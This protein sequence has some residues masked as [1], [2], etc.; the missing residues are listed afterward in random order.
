MKN[1]YYFLG[2]LMV[3]LVASSCKE[4]GEGVPPG[5]VTDVEAA[6][7]YGEVLLDWTN[8]SDENYYYVDISFVDSKGVNRS[9]KVSRYASGD[10]ITGFADT[11]AYTFSLTSYSFTGEASAPVTITATPLEPAFANVISTVEMVPDFGGAIVSWENETGKPVTVKVSYKD[12][13]GK[14]TSSLFVADESGKGYISGLASTLRNF[15]V[16]VSDKAN[17]NSVVRTFEITPLKEEKIS[18]SL[19][20]VVSFSS[21]EASG[22]GPS[23]G[24]VIH[25]IDDNISSFWH[26]QWQGASP[27]YPHWF[28]IDMHQAVTISRFECFRRQGS[29]SG[30]DKIKFHYS[31]DGT[32]WTDLG[33]FPFDR[34]TNNAQKYRITS[35]PK[36]RYF[37]FEAV[38]GPNNFTHLGEI[39]VY[40][41]TN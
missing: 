33:E 28:I 11:Q 21:E 19:W 41:A 38:A 24:R 32:T 39:S 12:D 7:G 25:A 4:K 18:K 31:M 37:K 22:E 17:N 26:S 30:S 29:S 16:V 34:N 27:G 5:Q 8:P 40:G 10:T 23:N 13:A 14:K 2:I 35:N 3:M 9:R 15:D 20:T 6:S 1:I 36:A